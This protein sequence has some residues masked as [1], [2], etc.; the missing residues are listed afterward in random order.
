MA[1]TVANTGAGILLIARLNNQF[2]SNKDLTLRLYTNDYTP[3]KTS[4]AG[5]FTEAAGGDYAAKTLSCG[6]WTLNAG[7]PKTCTYATQTFVFNGALN[8]SATIHGIYIT[9]ADGNLITAERDSVGFQPL[10]NLDNYIVVVLIGASSG[11]P[12]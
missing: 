5:N 9:D 12:S 1:Q 3:L 2:P 6:S 10:S 11:T 7:P 8:G 4:T